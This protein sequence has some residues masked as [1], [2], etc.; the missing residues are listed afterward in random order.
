MRS[1]VAVE[2][3]LTRHIDPDFGEFSVQGREEIT[4]R[5]IDQTVIGE[6]IG[7]PEPHRDI[8]PVASIDKV[9]LV[10]FDGGMM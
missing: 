7:N 8:C 9:E 1:A 6:C 10:V 4:V 3:V 2:G 5:L